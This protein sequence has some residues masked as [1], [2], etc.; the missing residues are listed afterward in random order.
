MK[1]QKIT[2]SADQEFKVE[3]QQG[4]ISAKSSMKMEAATMSI[5]G[6]SQASVKA[7]GQLELEGGGKASLKGAVVMIN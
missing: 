2:M 6:K 5:E 3:T 4:S 7:S 1:A